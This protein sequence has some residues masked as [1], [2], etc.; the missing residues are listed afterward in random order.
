MFKG[1]IK[2]LLIPP[3][4]FIGILIWWVVDFFKVICYIPLGF[5]HIFKKEIEDYKEYQK[6]FKSKVRAKK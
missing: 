3:I 1:I 4:F 6:K 5:V 2:V